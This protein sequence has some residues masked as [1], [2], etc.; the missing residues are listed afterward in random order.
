MRH[1]VIGM[2]TLFAAALFVAGWLSVDHL[3]T[4]QARVNGLH[5]AKQTPKTLSA[6]VDSQTLD[7]IEA[8]LIKRDYLKAFEELRALE[9]EYPENA[10]V[11]AWLGYT[12]Q[13]LQDYGQAL[14]YYQDALRYD[15]EKVSVWMQTG[16]VWLALGQPE[17]AVTHYQ[18][19]VKKWPDDA[20][21]VSA[22][23]DAYRQNRQIDASRLAYERAIAL[24][25]N[26]APAYYGLGRLYENAVDYSQ[27]TRYYQ[28]VIEKAPNTSDYAP[29]AKQAQVGLDRL[30]LGH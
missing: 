26:Y 20:A 25:H 1:S 21:L 9:A 3:N 7:V 28:K 14:L 16:K 29:Y 11:K 27:A 5:P 18:Q 15:A 22:M 30:K 19:A 17:Q 6:V 13:Q 10:E 12:H 2:T 8:D 4:G 24:D 23:A